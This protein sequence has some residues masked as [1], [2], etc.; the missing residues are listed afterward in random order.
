MLQ[1][2]AYEL[3]PAT[4]KRDL[5][6][7]H[8]KVYSMYW[9]ASFCRLLLSKPFAH[10]GQNMSNHDIWQRNDPWHDI[11]PSHT[12]DQC[13]WHGRGEKLTNGGQP[14]KLKIAQ[15]LH[16]S[17]TPN[18]R[19]ITQTIISISFIVSPTTTR[20][21]EGIC[22]SGYSITCIPSILRQDRSSSN[23]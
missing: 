17:S 5:S 23:F 2:Q 7:I 14:S 8:M 9:S 22:S 15:S 16:W 6:F 10:F 1:L 4:G 19:K 20:T 12:K 11:Q 13:N 18:H 21:Y 3:F